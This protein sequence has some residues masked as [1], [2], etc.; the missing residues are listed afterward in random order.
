MISLEYYWST[1]KSKCKQFFRTSEKISKRERKRCKINNIS[2][3]PVSR[4]FQTCPSNGT[5]TIVSL[6]PYIKQMRAP[7]KRYQIKQFRFPAF[8]K[9]HFSTATSH[10]RLLYTR[11]LVTNSHTSWIQVVSDGMFLPCYRACDTHSCKEQK[12]HKA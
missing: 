12:Q 1:E 8:S 11:K 2:L 7:R 6:L 9:Q 4:P 5:S 10:T 3:W